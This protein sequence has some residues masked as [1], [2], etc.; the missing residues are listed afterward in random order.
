[1]PLSELNLVAEGAGFEVRDVENLREHYART[2]R[3]WVNRLEANRAAAIRASNEM[4]YRTWQLYMS[5]SVWAFETGRINVNQT[6]LSK[7][8][9][10]GSSNLPL[11]RSDLYAL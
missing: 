7:N 3:H 6:L 1:M 4:L 10:G 2:L 9:A 11:A 8:G 5:S